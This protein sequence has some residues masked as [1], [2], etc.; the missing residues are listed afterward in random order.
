MIISVSRRT[1]IPAFYS[2]WFLNRIKE[3]FVFVKNPFNSNL[4]TKINLD[5]ENI[6][7]IVFWTKN[8]APLIKHLSKIRDYK[9]YFQFTIN[10]YNDQIEKKVPPKRNIIKTFKELSEKIGKDKVIWR[11]DPIFYTTQ[12]NFNYHLKYFN[13]LA[14]LIAPCTEKCVLSF[15][16]LYKKCENNLKGTDVRELNKEEI[17]VLIREFKTIANNHNLILETC[18]ED[19]DLI[20]YGVDHGKCI[21][22]KLIERIIGHRINFK[23]D[24]YQRKSCGCIESID[25]GE[26][27]TCRHNCIYCYANFN[28]KLVEQNVKKHNS[29]SPLLTGQITKQVRIVRYVTLFL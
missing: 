28:S 21:D 16:D 11:Y 25:I 13:E 27:N 29:L 3:R 22:N 23:K 24:K 18:A 20:N 12:I 26:Y 14:N 19:I 7:C 2:D 4:I 9:Y 6:D 5:P 15:L 10:P 8:P 1:D 17:I